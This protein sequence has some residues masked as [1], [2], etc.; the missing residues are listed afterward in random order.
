[1]EMVKRKTVTWAPSSEDYGKIIDE[2][3]PWHKTGE[4]PDAWAFTVERPLS[5]CLW[6]RVFEDK[7]RR[8]QLIFGPRRVGKTTAM[9]QTVRHLLRDAKVPKERIYWF[10]MD[11]PLLMRVGL[12][13]LIEIFMA[14]DP[15]PTPAN[16]VYFFLD[17][18]T[19]ATDWDLWLK[20]FYDESWPIRIVA[21]SSST[22]ALRERKPESGVGR[23]EERFLSPYLFSEFLQLIGDDIKIPVKATL[24]ETLE[25]CA[26]ENVSFDLSE[27]RKRY[28]LTGGFPE[29]LLGENS[30]TGQT[31]ESALL[32]SQR[33]LR[34]DAVQSAIYKDIP[35]AFGVDSPMMLERLLY[36]L[37]GQVTGLL[38]PNTICQT[39]EG[40]SQPTFDRYLSFLE[41]AFLVFT[42]PNYS[43][44]EASVQK[45]GRKLYFVDGAVRN[46]ALQR[47]LAP[48][49]NNEEMG[50]LLENMVAGHLYSLSQQ[51]QVRLYHWR[52]KNE[53]VDLAYDHPESPLAFE[54]AKGHHHR[55]GLIAFAE[56]FK[57]FNGRCFIV[58]AYAGLQMPRPKTISEI[59]AIPLD[60]FLLIVSAQAE[61]ELENNLLGLSRQA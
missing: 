38:S 8:F 18:L 42:L 44:S 13:R 16:P 11:H 45:R 36:T 48:L 28:L 47:G 6:R 29:L 56:R 34:S 53:E 21:S 17:E 10:R 37:A 50:V 4:V 23:W 19:Y 52:D 26:K 32:K 39:L 22:A 54:I 7:P 3:N 30:L 25:A 43:G 41:K 35:Q 9:F 59:G 31:D 33:I 40:M 14:V 46:A 49:S 1:M 55:W 5:K 24:W 27:K 12:G 58:S 15:K 51:T 61:K 20:T 57:R 60:L 2:Q